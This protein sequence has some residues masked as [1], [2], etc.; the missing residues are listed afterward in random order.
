MYCTNN[1]S[2][3]QDQ[4]KTFGA[5]T[6]CWYWCCGCI[7]EVKN[8][9][10]NCLYLS[11]H[12]HPLH[13]K[14]MPFLV[15]YYLIIIIIIFLLR[16]KNIN[17]CLIVFDECESG[18][19]SLFKR[20]RIENCMIWNMVER[21][22]FTVWFFLLADWESTIKIKLANWMKA[23]FSNLNSIFHYDYFWASFFQA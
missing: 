4:H 1:F 20:G 21:R 15:Q 10:I 7:F 22:N 11:E 17:A 5:C 8:H 23:Q 2:Y 13:T 16:K 14:R 19:R 12:R 6:E 18:T 3:F 9:F